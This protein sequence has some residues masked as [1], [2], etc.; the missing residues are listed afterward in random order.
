M[1]VIACPNC[2]KPSLVSLA[3]PDVMRCE[4]C[5]HHGSPPPAVVQ[6]L[7]E[8]AAVVA[9]S[10][11]RTRQLGESVKRALASGDTYRRRFTWI[12]WICS[13][14]IFLAASVFTLGQFLT[15]DDMNWAVFALG[16]LLAL[17]AVALG[18]VGRRLLARRQRSMEE[19]CAAR[20]PSTPGAPITCHL[21]GAPLAAHADAFVRCGFCAADNLVHPRVLARSRAPIVSWYGSQ[22]E[23]VERSLST[24]RA[25]N[26]GATVLMVLGAVAIPPVVFVQF[27]IG[28]II[29]EAI[30]D[31][32]D[33]SVRYTMVKTAA[34]ECVGRVGA[35]DDATTLVYFGTWRPVGLPRE[36]RLPSAQVHPFK[37]AALKGKQIRTH[38]GEVGHVKK[39]VGSPLTGNSVQL[40]EKAG[41]SNAITGL[42]LMPG[43][44]V[45]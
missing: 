28:V 6:S 21:C 36:M 38:L 12:F 45:P 40:V 11:M 2:G 7:R 15:K 17:E 18:I 13:T 43:E 19:A 9:R 32:I 14:P 24:M 44:H 31:S 1:P 5:G 35:H 30:D 41:G 33:P 20:P 22:I 29:I 4:A 26:Q 16:M 42:C 3:A 27:V 8:A 10:P 37:P 25:V 34:G 39:L 23:A